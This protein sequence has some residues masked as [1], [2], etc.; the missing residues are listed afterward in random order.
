MRSSADIFCVKFSIIAMRDL[1]DWSKI[2]DFHTVFF[3]GGEGWSN[4]P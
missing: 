2:L 4:R 3:G 1:G